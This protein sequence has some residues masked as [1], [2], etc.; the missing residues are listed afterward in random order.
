MAPG[1]ANVLWPP[2]VGTM[3]RYL[4][5]GTVLAT[6]PAAAQNPTQI[7]LNQWAQGLTRITDIAHCGDGRLFV[8]LQAGVIK[9]VLDS[10]VVAPTPFLDI[11]TLVN[12]VGNEQGLLG[13][14]FDPAY[15]SNGFF[16]VHYTAGSGAGVTRV[17]RFS[18]NPL[19]SS[20]ADPGSEHLIFTCP[21]P[22]TNHN[23]GDLDF[24]PDGMLYIS[25]GDG[26]S[27]D[28]PGGRGQ[29]YTEPLAGLL[30]LDVSDPD[31]TYLIPADN[32][33]AGTTS[34]TL[35]EIW[36]TGLRNPYRFGFDRLT[37][38]LWIGDVGQNR[39]EEVD[40]WPAGDNSCP[41]FGWRC[42]EGF[43]VCPTSITTGCPGASAFVD[44]VVEHDN[45]A[46]GG[47]W[48]SSIGGRV[49]RGSLWPHLYGHYVYTD[50][51]GQE[52]RSLL[53]DGSGGWV[54]SQLCTTSNYGYTVIAENADGELFT[55]NN[56]NGRLYK[57]LDK[58]P[59][60]PPTISYDG[61]T[62]SS[63]AANSYAWYVNGSPVVGATSQTYVPVQS[64][65]YYVVGTFTGGCSLQSDTLFASIVGVEEIAT[66]HVI[67][68]PNPSAGQVTIEWSRSAPVQRLTIVD[69]DGRV[70]LE[71]Q[72]TGSDRT[73]LSLDALADG[74]YMVQVRNAVDAVLATARLVVIR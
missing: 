33:F 19:D 5:L 73:L 24:G 18:V 20:V 36:A 68:A 27:G 26:G 13:L 67:V 9:I 46:N 55:G 42:R 12:D 15:T 48:C 40:F 66:P 8:T 59:M 71:R 29:D 52:F 22:Y 65:I 49:Y 44:P 57:I 16:Y 32:P 50:Y 35:P 31:T 72:V 23:G 17:S 39:W 74:A 1:V 58:C 56:V 34:D 38:D 14:V 43:H 53:P 61:T 70:H 47:T 25:L 54:D 69:A 2:I 64:G 37:G 63:S 7:K 10:N 3:K 45:V 6:L 30:R 11:Q 28:D 21:Q 60:E 41:N 4:L 51:C 62:L